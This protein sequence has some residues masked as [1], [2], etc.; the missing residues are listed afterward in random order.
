MKVIVTGGTGFTGEH[1]VH[2][3][4]SRGLEPTVLARQGSDRSR[5]AS[6]KIRW[7]EGDLADP[8]SLLRCFAGHDTL[9][10]VASIGFGHGPD[11]VRC[12]V[13]AGISRAV[14]TSTTA[15]LTRLPVRTKPVRDA[16][17]AAIRASPL[18]WTVLRPTMI[19][20]TERDRN[21]ARLLRWLARWRLMALPGGGHA[22]QQPVHVQDVA[23]ALV[24]AAQSSAAV[25]GT[26]TLSGLMPLSFRDMV[27]DAACAVG[28]K[29]L[30][31]PIPL[32]PLT[33]GLGACESLGVK[34][35]ITAEQIRRIAEDKAF[36]HDEAARD[37]GFIP[38]SFADGVR[39]QACLMRLAKG[40]AG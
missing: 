4:V 11:V 25:G 14:F 18:Q 33:S 40:R 34:L 2:E 13:E 19:Y 29:P 8:Q 31:L 17:E 35:R 5:F 39:Q 20:G 12:A 28:V 21:V 26:Y 6:L 36:P 16:A 1:V 37:F 3:L 38:R 7:V 23:R 22:L 27:C 30:L 24:D 32:A 9:I 15:I 10:N